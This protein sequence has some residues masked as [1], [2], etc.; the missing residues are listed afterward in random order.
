[1]CGS[2][3]QLIICTCLS[4]IFTCSSRL[5]HC[6][7]KAQPREREQMKQS[8]ESG[9]KRVGKLDEEQFKREQKQSETHLKLERLCLCYRAT[10][11]LSD[12]RIHLM[13]G[14]VC[15]GRYRSW[16]VASGSWIFCKKGTRGRPL[17][18]PSSTR[19]P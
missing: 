5:Q 12:N 11:L 10:Y 19:R 18:Y 9:E 2:L 17:L 6:R 1:M 8:N 16:G 14:K 3:R 4:I 7:R 13:A 15:L